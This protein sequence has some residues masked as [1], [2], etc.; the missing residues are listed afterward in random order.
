MARVGFDKVKT[1]GR[2][3]A[4][5]EIRYR[6]GKGP[7]TVRADAVIDASGT[8][9][10][11]NPAGAN[12]LEAIGEAEHAQRIAYGMPDVLGG[13]A[14]AAMPARSWPFSAPGIRLSAP[15]STWRA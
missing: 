3:N 5:F 15:F 2:E 11:P 14:C 12:G 13:A 10:T 7:S 9:D 6:N 1:A 4:P 8:W